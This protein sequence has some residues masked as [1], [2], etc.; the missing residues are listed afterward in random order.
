MH[1]S[2]M[3]FELQP[4]CVYVVVWLRRPDAVLASALHTQHMPSML[5]Q[6]AH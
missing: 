3:P 6:R 2:Q 5:G 4:Q 1:V